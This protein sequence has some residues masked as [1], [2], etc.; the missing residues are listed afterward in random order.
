[1]KPVLLMC[2]AVAVAGSVHGAV[3]TRPVEYKA[4]QITCKGIVAVDTATKEKRPGILVVP[5]WWGVNDF[6]T[7]KAEELAKMGYVAMVVDMYGD[8]KSTRDP[9]EAG[10]WSGAVKADRP[11]MRARA[12]AAL[13]QLKGQPETDPARTAAIGFCFGGT[14]VLEMARDNAEVLGV[15]SFH[16]GL[17]PG[18]APTAKEIKSKVLVLNGAADPGS[19][20]AV[21]G[22]LAREL[23]DAKADWYMVE[24]GHAV[25]GFMNPGAGTD[26][27]KGVAYNEPAA[28]RAWAEMK[29]FF[30]EIFAGS[31]EQ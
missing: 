5:E 25:H 9:K 17:Q 6:A 27:A 29:T 7:S 21:T 26:P 28:R 31:K 11:L 24:Y 10:E 18:N 12:E 16:G 20:P 8:G 19:Q 1:M 2:A 23:D 3:Q 13:A 22:A 15:V 30:A 4:G 14:T